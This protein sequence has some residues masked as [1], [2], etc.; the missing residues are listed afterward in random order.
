MSEI[1][2]LSLA[3]CRSIKVRVS[4]RVGFRVAEYPSIH[5]DRNNCISWKASSR[6]VSAVN[7]SDCNRGAHQ[8]LDLLQ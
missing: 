2:N 5:V 3:L 8:W 4:N 6:T 1:L 7:V